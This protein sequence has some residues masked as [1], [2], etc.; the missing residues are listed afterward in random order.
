MCTVQTTREMIRTFIC[1][2]RHLRTFLCH[3]RVLRI[4]DVLQKGGASSWK[5][6]AIWKVL[7]FCSSGYKMYLGVM[8]CGKKWTSELQC[9]VSTSCISRKIFS[10]WK[11]GINCNWRQCLVGTR[12]IWVEAFCGLFQCLVV[13]S[14][15]W[16]QCAVCRA[17]DE[18]RAHCQADTLWRHNRFRTMHN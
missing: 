7:G 6:A 4:F 8:L 3:E 1:P 2:E 5:K 18:L 10:G 14:C 17:M 15:I 11:V 12:L 9:L 16:R 13:T